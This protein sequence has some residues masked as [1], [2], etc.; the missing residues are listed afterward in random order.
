MAINKTAAGTWAVDFRDQHRRRIQRTF[1]THKAAADFEK[2]SLA[3]VAKREYVKPSG[4]TVQEVAEEWYQRK[5]NAGTYRRASL[6]DYRNHVENYIKPQLGSWKVYDIDIE[7]IE[8]AA[9][10]WGKKVSPKM[11]NKVLTSL[12]AIFALAKRYK[13]IKDNPAQEAERL[14]I[15]TENE[16]DI[17]VT[18]DKVLSKEEIRKLIQATE[19]GSRD[20]LM[21]MVPAFTGMRIGEVLGLTWS[22]VN[23]KAGKLDVRLN[24][25]DSDKGKPLL[26]QPPKTRSSRRTVPL[27]PELIRE[28][29]VW[30]LKCPRSEQDLVFAT[31]DGKAYHRNAAS[32]ALDKAIVKAEIKRITPHGLRHTF[33]SLLLADGVAVPEVSA[34]LGHKDSYVTWK[35]YAHFVKKESTAVHDLAASILAGSN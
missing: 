28:L 8:K 7:Q 33:A 2:D 17:E 26:L 20:R 13:L 27:P 14:K 11:V 15:A 30:K 12:T 32:D 16:D 3:Q 5:V 23:L 31:E 4:K 25:A 6:I 21:V 18:P 35:V 24:L 9:A 29:K 10:E 1:E 19:P 34:L 22:A